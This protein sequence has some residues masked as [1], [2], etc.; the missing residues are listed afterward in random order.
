[1]LGLVNFM[2]LTHIRF[3]MKSMRRFLSAF[4][5][6]SSLFSAGIL[7]ANALHCQG[8]VYENNFDIVGA[9]IQVYDRGQVVN[10]TTTDNGGFYALELDLGSDYVIVIS[11][12]GYV[13]KRF[14]VNTMDVPEEFAEKH[15]SGINVDVVLH[16]RMAG[17]DYSI[18]EK[19]LN[20]YAYNPDK[21]NF[22][23]DLKYLQQV[24][25]EL[26][27]V[28]EAERLARLKLKEKEAMY[29]NAIKLGDKYYAARD[30]KSALASYNEALSLRPTETYPKMQ[31]ELINKALADAD[32]TKQLEAERAAALASEAAAKA[33]ADE[34]AR[35]KAEADR[36]AKEKM[37]ADAR[38]AAEA[39]AKADA[40]AKLEEEK[41]AKA[42]LEAE[43]KAKR[44]SDARIKA[45]AER[46]A[47]EKAK[48]ELDAKAEAERL[49]KEKADAELRQKAEEAA[50]LKA[51][52]ERIAKEN[53]A[54]LK[55][56]KEEEMIAAALKADTEARKKAEA[57][58]AQRMKEEAEAAVKAKAEA[59]RMAREQREADALA[60][61][62]A[63][64]DRLAAMKAEAEFK[65]KEKAEAERMAKEKA[66]NEKIAKEK[67]LAE[68]KQKAEK[69]KLA[70]ARYEAD[71]KK[72]NEYY[73][74]KKFREALNTYNELITVNSEDAFIKERI[75]AC[76][77]EL[78][79]KLSPE[80]QRQLELRAKYP[81]G[82]TEEVTSAEGVM[83]ERR[84]LVKA[85]HVYVYEKKTFSWGGLAYF[86]D[87]KVI[88][89]IVFET[90]TKSN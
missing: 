29:V 59:E 82:L 54:A 37:E 71:L 25:I 45:E 47:A 51:E 5:W 28:Y 64:D 3:I 70:K 39:K 7:Q 49:A 23:F 58:R 46:L 60:K 6:I 76:E 62:K 15:F 32:S 84:I 55:K 30:Y 63:E 53:A 65:A 38:L 79:G 48:L 19:P 83:I 21:I 86:R 90:E 44:E 16:K 75:A 24:K 14:T 35:K 69:E 2:T 34:D 73:T 57:E 17:V 88:T 27:A 52:E 42:K 78:V 22:E 26:E 10:S 67:A 77:K 1:M 56:Q 9:L 36:I 13:S 41:I 43:A 12:E 20:K 4:L 40:A 50:R 18:M 74:A 8:N 68:A 31:V 89:G 11:K 72:A 85:D 61:K 66:L 33:K 87:G 80:E 81:M